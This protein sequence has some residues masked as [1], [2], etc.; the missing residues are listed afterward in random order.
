ML[1]A[2]SVW[3]EKLVGSQ[4]IFFLDNDAVSSPLICAEGATKLAS[5]AVNQFVKLESK[6][7]CCPCFARVPSASN[8]ADDASRLNF[9]T[10][11]L[12]GVPKP[13]IVLPAQ[14]SQWGM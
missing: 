8:P 9:D 13:D 5:A 12:I 14:L 2:L 3:Q 10:P 6:L 7:K 1:L 11:W 4:V